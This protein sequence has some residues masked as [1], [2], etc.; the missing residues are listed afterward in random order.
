MIN[1]NIPGRHEISLE[2]AVFD[3]NGTLGT[4]GV[5]EDKLEEKIEALSKR[6][7]IYVVSSDTYGTV[8]KQCEKLPIESIV[9]P[10]GKCGDAKKEFVLSLGKEKTLCVGNGYND[11]PMLS[12]GELSIVIIGREG[13]SVKA[14]QGADVVF[15]NIFDA[16]D[17]L[18]NDKRM[19]ATL[20]K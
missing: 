7:K 6:V 12:V 9:L 18:L 14:I 8:T 16:M 5:L 11:Y 13:A 15:A 3:F 2:Y 10:K 1:V 19:V 4:D 20:R 17:F